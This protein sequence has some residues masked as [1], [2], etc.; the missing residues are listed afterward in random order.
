[1]Y[2]EGWTSG[3]Y[4]GEGSD[5]WKDENPGKPDPHN[6]G[7]FKWQVYN[8]CN[9]QKV[10]DGVYLGSFNDT[11]RNQLRGG[12]DGHKWD[13]YTYPGSGFV[14]GDASSGKNVAEGLW[15]A[16][17]SVNSG[18]GQYDGEGHEITVCTGI[19]S[20]QTVNYASCHDNW[21]VRDQLYDTVGSG[22]PADEG[23]SN[24]RAYRLIRESIMAHSLIFS[25][26][27]PAFMQ[28]GEELFRTKELG[29]D[30]NEHPE[31]NVKPTD[32]A[33]MYGHWICHNSYNTPKE[34]NAFKW[35][36]KQ[37][38]VINY[39]SYN[40]T[41][42]AAN[43]NG[44]GKCGISGITGIFADMIKL[45]TEM[46]KR[47]TDSATSWSEA[48][49]QTSY[50]TNTGDIA[51]HNVGSVFWTDDSKTYGMQINEVFVYMSLT[52]AGDVHTD[53]NVA[54]GGW[55]RYIKS[56]LMENAYVDPEGTYAHLPLS[57]VSAICVYN[58]RG[59]R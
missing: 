13:V 1:M 33:P 22:D 44:E 52:D 37:S 45:H 6:Y 43:W 23:A 10:P 49:G 26:N 21:T 59:V 38:F 18:T 27:T 56:G 51:H 14:Q 53:V 24:Q 46:D 54:N 4:H 39:N 5:E 3:G 42:D 34:V 35:N 40:T 41:I 8:E 31:Y 25:A 11:T 47:G 7:A 20:E 28:G 48:F 29:F 32:T 2:G 30:P 50:K 55:E 19:H 36:N 58:A 15:G 12:N 16:D 17:V 9:K 57:E